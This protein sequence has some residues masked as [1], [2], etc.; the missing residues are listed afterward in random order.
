MNAKKKKKE[1][2]LN[3]KSNVNIRRPRVS[4]FNNTTY[5]SVTLVVPYIPTPRSPNDNKTTKP[6]E[7]GKVSNVAHRFMIRDDVCGSGS[8][9]GAFSS[10]GGGNRQI[11][12]QSLRLAFIRSTSNDINATKKVI[13]NKY[14]NVIAKA[15]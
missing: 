12:R 7:T 2:L 5:L 6:L 8:T 13:I 14:E 15:A 3:L 10:S 11:G 1:K 9:H 4:N